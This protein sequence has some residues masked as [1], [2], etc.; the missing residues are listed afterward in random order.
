MQ[1]VYELVKLGAF[2]S[3]MIFVLHLIR[4]R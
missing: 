1:M 4:L 3:C 2:T